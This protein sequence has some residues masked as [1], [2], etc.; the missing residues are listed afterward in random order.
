MTI[1]AAVEPRSPD[2]LPDDWVADH[3][4]CQLRSSRLTVLYG[5]AA[6]STSPF[7]AASVVPRLGRRQWDR[8]LTRARQRP[9]TRAARGRPTPERR[10]GTSAEML[11]LVDRWSGPAIATLQNRIN[12]SFESAGAYMTSVSLP[13]ADSLLAWSQLLH[14]RFLIIFDRFEEFLSGREDS[15]DGR[16]FTRELV[17]VLRKPGLDVNLLL[18]VAAGSEPEMQRY[19]TQFADFEEASCARL[20]LHR[21]SMSRSASDLSLIEWREPPIVS[22]I[23]TAI[24]TGPGAHDPNSS[25]SNEPPLRAKSG[26]RAAFAATMTAITLFCWPLLPPDISS[27]AASYFRLAARTLESGASELIH[28]IDDGRP[29]KTKP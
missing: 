14:L 24:A 15:D 4:A 2:C 13:I 11:V 21:L 20:P 17:Q 16:R 18:C 1:A 5:G 10:S 6:G 3:L 25:A 8:R 19:L 27:A 23:A 26:L 28:R 7:I 29:E 12:D 22:A 9:L